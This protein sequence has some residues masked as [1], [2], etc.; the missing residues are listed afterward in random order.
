MVFWEMSQ[1]LFDGLLLLFSTHFHY[2]QDCQS[3]TLL[4][5]LTWWIQRIHW[6]PHTAIWHLVLMEAAFVLTA[7]KFCKIKCI[8]P[9]ATSRIKMSFFRM[10]NRKL[11]EIIIHAYL[12][13][14]FYANCQVFVIL[15]G[16]TP[17]WENFALSA[18]KH[19]VTAEIFYPQNSHPYLNHI[20][21][22]TSL[23]EVWSHMWYLK[24]QFL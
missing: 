20:N 18:V 13:F 3:A 24:M 17:A 4:L 15:S 14:V 1:Q 21:I 7:M 11:K 8:N 23:A 22:I 9:P 6:S 5:A 2:K 10:Q 12:S 19:T 16:Y